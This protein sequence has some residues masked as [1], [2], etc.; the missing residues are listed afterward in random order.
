MKRLYSLYFKIL[1]FSFVVAHVYSKMCPRKAFQMYVLERGE[2]YSDPPH[3]QAHTFGTRSRGHF[4]SCLQTTFK[5]VMRLG[6]KPKAPSFYG[7]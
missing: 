4:F 6:L 7:R 1:F 2:G 3:A 5:N